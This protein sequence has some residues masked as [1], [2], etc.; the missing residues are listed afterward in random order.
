MKYEI[1]LRQTIQKEFIVVIEADN[2]V[3]AMTKSEE[4]RDEMDHPDWCFYMTK[5]KW[6]AVSVKESKQE[7]E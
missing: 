2:V 3:E 4:Y 7:S 5:S 6:S 1:K